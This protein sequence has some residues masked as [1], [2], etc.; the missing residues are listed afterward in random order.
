MRCGQCHG[1]KSCPEAAQLPQHAALG[2]Q[3]SFQELWSV[4][5]DSGPLVPGDVRGV[6]LEAEA[7][8]LHCAL[9][10]QK[11]PAADA[12]AGIKQAL[13]SL[14]QT[15]YPADSLPEHHG[16]ILI[17]QARLL[18]HPA[19]L[20]QDEWQAALQHR[21]RCP[22]VDWDA[23]GHD[24][25]WG[26]HLASELSFLIALHMPLDSATALLAPAQLACIQAA[27]VDA[28]ESSSPACTQQRGCS[29]CLM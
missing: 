13:D 4:Q 22:S 7:H 9:M 25:Q 15:V 16:R 27:Y 2:A 19:M 23:G 21:E 14:L 24:L 20:S 1:R 8:A 12:H 18:Q 3:A 6:A 17:L 26:H 28:G 10:Q 5:E 11:L 29:R